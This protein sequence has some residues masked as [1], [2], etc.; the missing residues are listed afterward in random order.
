MRRGRI[1]FYLAFIIILLVVAGFVIWQRFFNAPGTPIAEQPTPE[2]TPVNLVDVIVVTQPIPR[3]ALIDETVLGV[4]PIPREVLIQG[5]FTDMASVVGRQA[6]F[7]LDAGIPL[8]ASMLVDSAEQ[9]SSTGSTAALSIPAGSVA[10]S[11]PISRLSS[12]SYAPR[13]GD[14]VIVIASMLFVDID[15][16]YQTILPNQAGSVLSP[17]A[18]IVIG[19]GTGDETGTQFQADETANNITARIVGGGSFSILGRTELDPVLNELIYVIPSESQRPRL[20]S[21]TLLKD[22]I[23]L[24]IGDFK[25]PAQEEAEREQEIIA[26]QEAQ[27]QQE[28]NQQPVPEATAEPEGPNPPDLITLVVSPQDAVTLNYMMYAGAELTLALRAAG[29][30]SSVDTEA[31]TLQFLL[32]TYNIP[33]PAKLPYGIEP[34]VDELFSP[35]ETQ[36]PQQVQQP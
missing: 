26:A 7:D 35:L 4:V 14:H 20:V 22:V 16:D 11:I 1:F 34:R 10:V 30:T 23:V 13:S 36:T 15:T 25:Y 24:H 9:L 17:G 29:D 8:T 18:G 31:A 2:A 21:Q 12:V 27:Q 33:I 3:G 6:K 32:D 5:M 28:Q 19:S